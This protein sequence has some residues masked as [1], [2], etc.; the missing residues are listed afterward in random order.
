MVA[1][2]LLA[3]EIHGKPGRLVELR[4]SDILIPEYQREVDWPRVKRCAREFNWFLFG[5]LYVSY[6]P[7]DYFVVDGRN[8]LEMVRLR[9]EIDMAPCMVFDFNGPQHE[10]EIFVELQKYRKP[11]VTKDV[12]SAE[13]FAGG[14]FGATAR[15]AE[16]FVQ[17]LDCET[18]PLASIRKLVRSKPEAFNR[19]APLISNLVGPLALHKDF[20]EAIV[21]LE[22]VLGPENSLADKHRRLLLHTGYERLLAAMT[23]YHAQHMEGRLAKVASPRLKA[24]A[25]RWAL[26]E[27]GCTF[28]PIG[29]DGDL[30]GAEAAR[31]GVAAG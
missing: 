5:V 18:V 13:L 19:I 1:A 3:K 4:K 25:L 23:T 8:R 26:F 31:A 6:R 22:D 21:Y 28:E 17:G 30:I 14:D 7:P 2:A 10:A 29:P 15:A 27:Q 11:L 20:I 12:H 9:P 16:D 24:D